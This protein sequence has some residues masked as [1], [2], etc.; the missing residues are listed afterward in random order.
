MRV[1]LDLILILILVFL[2]FKGGGWWPLASIWI[3]II[4]FDRKWLA[5]SRRVQATTR[6]LIS[7]GLF[8]SLAYWCSWVI[9]HPLWLF[10][11]AFIPIGDN[12]IL[13]FLFEGVP[14]RLFWS[15]ALGTGM[16]ALISILT[17]RVYGNLVAPGVYGQF[18]EYRGHEK[19]ATSH[20]IRDLIGLA[21]GVLLVSRG[22]LTS[23]GGAG[24]S[25]SMFGGPGMLI[26]QAGH[27]VILEQ[28]GA[29][30]RVV[31]KGL[32]MLQEFEMV[33]MVVPLS[34][35]TERITVQDVPTNDQIVITE[36]EALVFHKADP[37][38]QKDA[39]G[40]GS[41]PYNAAILVDKI[42]GPNGG[43]WRTAVQS[44][45]STAIR[46][47]VGRYNLEELVPLSDQVRAE[48]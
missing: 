38:P 48:L 12:R 18:E 14:S 44:I 45:A 17:L 2:S 1:L 10:E 26:V 21:P 20:V 35:R 8:L 25:V 3:Y 19:E 33:G 9:Y 24:N 39:L 46:D 31:S 43:D 27:A 40:D 34:T 4:A 15:V 23:I 6:F 32:T 42:W 22:E 5:L 16:A 13:Q 30:S 11:P 29:I 36:L 41:Y 28:T 47:L 7:L 37:G